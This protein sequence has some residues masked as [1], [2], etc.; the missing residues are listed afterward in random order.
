V[1]EKAREFSAQDPAKANM[2]MGQALA[3]RSLVYFLLINFFSQPYSYTPDASHPGVAYITTSDWTQNV[4]GRN[5]VADVYQHL[6]TDLNEAISLLPATSSSTLVMNRNAAKALLARIYLFKGDYLSAKNMSVEVSRDVPIMT[7][8]YP[9]KLFTPQETE[10]L[11]QL[12]PGTSA[13][14]KY[15]TTF[16]NFYFRS[17][18]QFQA[19]ADI[20]LLLGETPGD[21]RK[22]WV[23]ASSSNWNITKYPSGATSDATTDKANAYWQTLL[24]S[25]EMYLVAAE[26][27]ANLNN[28]DSAIFYLNAI[29]QRANAAMTSSS[30]LNSALLDT[31][32]KERRKE[33]AFEG[34]RMFDLQRWKKGVSRGDALDSQKKNLPYPNNKAI[35]PIPET[36][37]DVLGLKQNDDY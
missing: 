16:A 11:F 22:N 6:V 24:R 29:Q 23:T 9:A 8:N 7:T 28:K 25:S 36:D 5:T 4:T 37:V 26:C 15:T 12:P 33:L 17:R 14:N 18:I 32:Y 1:I 3:I 21:L 30:I 27:Y 34:L 10:A 19:T 13:A 31:I 20:A 35:A 2:M